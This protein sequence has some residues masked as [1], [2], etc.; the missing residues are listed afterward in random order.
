MHV[1]AQLA[2]Q[3]PLEDEELEEIVPDTV[4]EGLSVR[5]YA[6]L[7]HSLDLMHR[8]RPA[9]AKVTQSSLNPLEWDDLLSAL[10]ASNALDNE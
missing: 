10:L 2:S 5:S 1:R 3:D 6:L 8:Y 4:A 7:E 9:T